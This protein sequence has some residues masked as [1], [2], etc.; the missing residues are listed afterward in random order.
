[1]SLPHLPSMAA[2]PELHQFLLLGIATIHADLDVPR[3][4]VARH[5]V[6]RHLRKFAEELLLDL[7]C[8]TVRISHPMRIRP[9]H[10]LR[11][12]RLFLQVFDVLCMG[13]SAADGRGREP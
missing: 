13:W 7:H 4:G 10:I 2:Q 8:T 9:A 3:G 11:T 12:I 1:M 5:L 6:H